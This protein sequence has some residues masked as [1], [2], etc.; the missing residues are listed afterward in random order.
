MSPARVHVWFLRFSVLPSST[1]QGMCPLWSVAGSVS[2]S[3][4]PL[5]RGLW[6]SLSRW[7]KSLLRDLSSRYTFIRPSHS[8]DSPDMSHF[9]MFLQTFKLFTAH[10]LCAGSLLGW[11]SRQNLWTRLSSLPAGQGTRSLAFWAHRAV[12]QP[13]GDCAEETLGLLGGLAS[14][15]GDGRVLPTTWGSPASGVCAYVYVYMYV[16]VCMCACICTCECV[17]TCVQEHPI[18]FP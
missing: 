15:G 9:R 12:C 5:V 6:S 18:T 10:L 11:D 16:Q 14:P 7:M 17:R 2:C 13:L 1:V 3:P 4:F 8:I